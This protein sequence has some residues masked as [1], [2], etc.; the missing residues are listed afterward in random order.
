MRRESFRVGDVVRPAKGGDEM[1]VAAVRLYLE[2]VRPMPGVNGFMV[3]DD[4]VEMVEPVELGAKIAELQAVEQKVPLV[5]A[6]CL[7]DRCT[8][9]VESRAT[10]GCYCHG[11][12]PRARS[13]QGMKRALAA[14]AAFADQAEHHCVDQEACPLDGLSP[15][16][17]ADLRR[18]YGVTS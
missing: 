10:C 14:A 7:V 8:S 3:R 1:R 17:I 6:S 9:C 12:T 15:K 11:H 4:Q 13:N 16:T 5:C 18:R 2:P